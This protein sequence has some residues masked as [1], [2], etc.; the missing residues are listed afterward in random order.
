MSPIRSPRILVCVCLASVACGCAHETPSSQAASNR[1]KESFDAARA[2]CGVTV[3]ETAEVQ[4]C[5]R[6]KGWNYRLPWQ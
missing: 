3:A 4:R 1:T 6:A 5:M 2:Q